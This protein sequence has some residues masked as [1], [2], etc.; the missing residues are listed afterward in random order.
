VITNLEDLPEYIEFTYISEEMNL[1]L[2]AG[3]V[4]ENAEQGSF[5]V[6]IEFTDARLGTSIETIN[7]NVLGEVDL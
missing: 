1:I 7:I 5:E 2:N 4:P 6:E 3:K